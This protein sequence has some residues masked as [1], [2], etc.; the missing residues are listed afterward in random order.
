MWVR[1][2]GVWQ[3]RDRII[4]DI[5][6]AKR[7]IVFSLDVGKRGENKVEE[8]L[9][10]TKNILQIYTKIIINYTHVQKSEFLNE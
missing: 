6:F 7:F 5:Y 3:P 2:V 8:A 1:R 9:V 4:N 10:A